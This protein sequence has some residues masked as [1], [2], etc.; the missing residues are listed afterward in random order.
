M[1]RVCAARWNKASRRS[2]FPLLRYRRIT[3]GRCSPL[4]ALPRSAPTALSSSLDPDPGRSDGLLPLLVLAAHEFRELLGG[5]RRRL[6]AFALEALR[7]LF[8]LKDTHRLR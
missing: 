1:R 6:G 4:C 5:S 3:D 8:V 2:S 7:D